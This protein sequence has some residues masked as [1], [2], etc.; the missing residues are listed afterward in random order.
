MESVARH[1]QD[2]LA[3]VRHLQQLVLD[4][5]RFKGFSGPSRAASG[6][7][8]LV[9]AAVMASPLYPESVRWHL[10]GWAGVFVVAFALN[11]GALIY[12]FFN[13]PVVKKDVRRLKPLLD[14]VPPLFVGGALTFAIILHG[15]YPYLFG[16]WMCMFGLSNMASRH[17]LPRPIAAVGI[18]YI[19]CGILLVLA[20]NSSFLNPLPMGLV[21][22]AGEW[23]SGLILYR[24]DKRLI[25][26]P[27][28]ATER[29]EDEDYHENG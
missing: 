23:A 12:W 1:I 16:I 13:D 4:S 26:M 17:V 25:D 29:G 5:Q 20:P 2:A 21:F 24:D 3:Q 15:L 10:L 19:L 8:A 28:P 18:F 7:I 14:V 9:A 22:C 27:A 11:F 6:T